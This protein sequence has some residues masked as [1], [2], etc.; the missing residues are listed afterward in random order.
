[1]MAEHETGVLKSVKYL[2]DWSNENGTY[3]SITETIEKRI[4]GT[5]KIIDYIIV[6]AEIL[7]LKKTSHFLKPNYIGLTPDHIL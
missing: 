6:I 7:A 2:G 3:A 4:N 1:M 5:K